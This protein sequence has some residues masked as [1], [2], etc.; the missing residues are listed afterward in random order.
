MAPKKSA[1]IRAKTASEASI[2][3]RLAA[4]GGNYSIVISIKI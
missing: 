1:S 3:S 2:T 4:I